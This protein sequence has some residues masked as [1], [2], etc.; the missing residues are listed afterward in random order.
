MDC[1]SHCPFLAIF[2]L[3]GFVFANGI[4]QRQPAAGPMADEERE[5][6]N[7]ESGVAST[8]TMADGAKFP[9]LLDTFLGLK[10]SRR[11]GAQHLV[12]VTFILIGIALGEVDDRLVKCVAI[13]EVLAD[14]D[15]IAR[16]GMGAS[17]RPP[18][19]LGVVRHQARGHLVDERGPFHVPELSPV[20]MATGV[21]SARPTQ[22]DVA[23]CLD[24]P[25][26]LDHTFAWLPVA[27]PWQVVLQH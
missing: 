16:A 26:A 23:G 18:T 27:A 3:L 13:A 14:G 5:M 2:A 9:A 20:E 24:H 21:D 8:V 17:Q 7:P 6:G 4:P 12:M 22:E 15:G 1:E 10:P 25:L 19:Q 11:N